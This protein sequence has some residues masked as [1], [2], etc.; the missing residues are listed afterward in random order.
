MPKILL[1][2]DDVQ[3]TDKLT[4]WLSSENY[5]V[6]SVASG[7]DALQLLEQTAYDIIVLDWT[8]ADT[9][10][11]EV[12]KQFRQQGGKTP[13][14]FL[15][16]RGDI[17]NKEAGLNSGADDYLVKPFDVRE[18]SA[19]LRALL[20]RPFEVTMTGLE[21][22]GLRLEVESRTAYGGTQCL[23][24]TPRE[25]DI[26]EYLLRHPNRNYTAKSLL[27]YVW[28]LDT[29]SSEATVRT[30]V[31]TLRQ[32][33]DKIGHLDLIKNERGSGYIIEPK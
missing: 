5:T 27:N 23:K 13:I 7:A 3:L 21:A 20:R 33:L 28:P 31:K 9:T 10:G 14:I 25:C 18:L 32:K 16:G 22:N 26:L 8:L 2:D 4:V 6:E 19:R 30:I 1:V 17:A 24:L 12:C 11:L 15:T 29:D